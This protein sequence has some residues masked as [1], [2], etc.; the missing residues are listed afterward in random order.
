MR[1]RP[2]AD[3]PHEPIRREGTASRAAS[4]D[5]SGAG[6]EVTG[7]GAGLHACAPTLLGAARRWSPS[8]LAED[9]LQQVYLIA[10]QQGHGFADAPP[11]GWLLAIL[12][13]CC[14]SQNRRARRI[15]WQSVETEVIHTE[16][17]GADP[18]SVVAAAELESRVNAE[19]ILLPE[20]YRGVIGRHFLGQ[21]STEIASQLGR[22]VST[23][24]TQLGRGLRMLRERLDRGGQAT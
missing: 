15:R 11:L 14:R 3:S 6:A 23:V 5:R 19:V 8:H 16:S 21:S 10:L 20:P 9:L 17:R 1:H 7:L 18:V 12:H 2:A 22:P 4:G 24:R 13:N